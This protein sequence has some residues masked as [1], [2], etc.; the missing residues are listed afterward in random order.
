MT[1]LSHVVVVVFS[2]RMWRSIRLV[3]PFSLSEALPWH[4][5][6]LAL[7]AF[8]AVKLLRLIIRANESLTVFTLHTLLGLSILC[9]LLAT[10]SSIGGYFWLM[11]MSFVP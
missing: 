5:F 1:I 3:K 6:I 2:F 8:Q 4:L 9:T 7:S 10:A 11:R